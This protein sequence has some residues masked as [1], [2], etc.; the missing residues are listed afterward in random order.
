MTGTII[1]LAAAV[2]AFALGYRKLRA[3]PRDFELDPDWLLH[4]SSDRYA[5]LGRMLAGED[6]D[7]ILSETSGNHRKCEEFRSCRRAAF[8]KYL[9][10]LSSDFTKLQRVAKMV[11]ADSKQDEAQLFLFL[12][13][14]AVRFR[15]QVA[16]VRCNLALSAHRRGN[17]DVRRLLALVERTHTHVFWMAAGSARPA[18]F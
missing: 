6:Y 4:F 8:Q 13:A 18:E 17:V 5:I 1:F 9:D 11:V 14:Q 10:E 16:V 7:W 12:V 2:V 3:R 15:Y